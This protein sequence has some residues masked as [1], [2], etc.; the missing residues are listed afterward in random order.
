MLYRHCGSIPAPFSWEPPDT[1]P[2]H[3]HKHQN[4]QSLD[5]NDLKTTASQFEKENILM[6]HIQMSN[7]WVKKVL[8]NKKTHDD[9][10]WMTAL[11]IKS[12]YLYIIQPFLCA[13]HCSVLLLYMWV[14]DQLLY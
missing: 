10:G 4:K 8:G 5:F 12:H 9:S 14:L 6:T 7:L 11:T 1:P 13:A 3:H 2:L